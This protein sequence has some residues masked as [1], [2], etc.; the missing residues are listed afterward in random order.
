MEIALLC[1]FI[2]PHLSYNTIKLPFKHISVNSIKIVIVNS[3]FLDFFELMVTFF[4]LRSNIPVSNFLLNH[5]R[6]F[7]FFLQSFVREL[8]NYLRNRRASIFV[9]RKVKECQ[10]T[11]LLCLSKFD[12]FHIK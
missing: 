10:V 12:I 5:S 9:K 3:I 2:R 11:K 8:E 6:Q 1:L 4:D 7:L